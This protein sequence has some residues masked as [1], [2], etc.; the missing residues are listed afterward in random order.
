[1]NIE[2]FKMFKKIIQSIEKN[3]KWDVIKTKDGRTQESERAYIQIIK[4]EMQ[5]I[6]AIVNCNSS[7]K[8]IDFKNV[9]WP[10]GKE[11]SFECKKINKGTK[12]MFND[13][14]P[15]DDVYYIFIYVDTKKVIIKKGSSIYENNSIRKNSLKSE[16]SRTVGNHVLKMLTTND[17]T[18]TSILEFFKITMIF[19]GK[20]VEY[21]VLSCFDFGQIF[22]NTFIFGNFS[23]RARPNWSVTVNP[24]TNCCD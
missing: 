23:S 18:K 11:Y 21:K 19:M 4:E 9:Q 7:Q 14:L 3:L 24:L 22:K 16:F 15:K 1:M 20:S 10:N 12:F 6:G 8:H 5:K 17:F 2:K 13:T